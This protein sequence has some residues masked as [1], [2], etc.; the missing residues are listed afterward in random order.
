MYK[1]C[2]NA[3]KILNEFKDAPWPQ[4]TH[5]N[6]SSSPSKEANP[7][8]SSSS[9]ATATTAINNYDEDTTTITTDLE[10]ESIATATIID[11][12]SASH[13]HEETNG[14]QSNIPNERD[15]DADADA[16]EIEVDSNGDEHM[17]GRGE[18]GLQDYDE[19]RVVKSFESIDMNTSNE[20][21]D[22][23]NN[24]NENDN[25]KENN[26]QFDDV[27][28]D[29]ENVNTDIN[30]HHDVIDNENDPNTGNG[31]HL[32]VNIEAVTSEDADEEEMK[33]NATKTLSE[34]LNTSNA[35]ITDNM[36]TS[37]LDDHRQNNEQQQMHPAIKTALSCY[38]AVINNESSTPKMV[39]I[40]LE[41]I[42]LLISNRYVVGTTIIL[43]Q[44]SSSSN[45]NAQNG[46]N[47]NTS[48]DSNGSRE[49][50]GSNDNNSNKQ[51]E[52]LY[53]INCIC[54]RADHVSETVQSAMAKA[55]LA[56]MT[57]PVCGVYEA[58]ML[59]AVRTVFHIYLVTKHDSVKQVSRSVLLD[60]LR[61]VFSRMEAYDAITTQYE[62]DDTTSDLHDEEKS[63]CLN[64][65][66]SDEQNTIFASRFHTDSYLLFRALCKLS[67]KLL[68][69]D[70]NENG[71]V[72]SG[73]KTIFS[74]NASVA[75]PMATNT[76][77]L[78]LRLIL[79]VF[80]NCGPA[81]R[82]GEKFIYA[83]QN[84]LC[85]SLVKNSMSN[86]PHVAHLSLKVF[87]LLVS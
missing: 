33:E 71:S 47:N 27:E 28:F 2:N 62:D 1:K 14:N 40:A 41:C 56:L 12:V 76:K 34:T 74:S 42:G 69:E 4:K 60:M 85:V 78:S 15:V 54:E 31:H 38:C 26:K 24:N 84:F 23:D 32:A 17:N 77:I 45:N 61:S 73:R 53:L 16:D 6:P 20:I 21:D 86:N 72:S 35:T 79:S 29:D 49:D 87:L 82:D 44:S 52:I 22:D 55:L 75:D 67:A 30:G 13:F 59:K 5:K 10:T 48:V 63:L 25:Q 19:T 3:I 68:P 11:D 51:S 36:Y 80:E 65:S 39:E 81:F 43:K 83:V 9:A 18:N 64:T 66:T 58:G 57:S 37:V 46:D 50:G 70:A 8:S 7:S